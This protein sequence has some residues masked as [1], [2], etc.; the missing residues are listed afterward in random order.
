MTRCDDNGFFL[1][2]N[3]N[4]DLFNIKNQKIFEQMQKTSRKSQETDYSSWDN[5]VY[6][7][8]Y[9]NHYSY[10]NKTSSNNWGTITSN[11]KGWS[12]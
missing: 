5:Y 12:P 1:D 8:T 11:S 4:I 3:G 9:I 7:P 10:E 2:S 6:M